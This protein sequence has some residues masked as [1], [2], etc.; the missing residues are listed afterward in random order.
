[1]NV[2]YIFIVKASVSPFIN[3]IFSQEEMKHKFWEWEDTR[4]NDVSSSKCRCMAKVEEKLVDVQ[5]KVVEVQDMV[6]GMKKEWC[7]MNLRKNKEARVV[8]VLLFA[9]WV[10]VL[11]H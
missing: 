5:N 4:L 8:L 10:T 6:M 1:M 3:Y 9:I 7:A 2:L 11:L